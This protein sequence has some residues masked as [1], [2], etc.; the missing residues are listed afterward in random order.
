M[1]NSSEIRRLIKE[2]QL[3]TGYIDLEIQLQPTGFDLSLRAVQRYKGG[4]KV[5]FSNLE[6]EIAR[7]ELLEPDTD[8]WYN[9]EVGCYTIV[10]NEVVKIPLDVVAMARSR[11][12]LLRNG[13]TVQTAIWD[14]GYQGRS[15][16]LLVVSNPNGIRLKRDA[17]LTQLVFFG[18][19]KVQRG[20]DGIYQG[21]RM[22]R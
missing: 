16:S 10:Y 15:S 8:D 3:I 18:T 2:R 17:R 12:T 21:E 20:Y 14:P 1:F 4:G 13:A 7:K 5:D 9:L 6:R 19:D 22:T 11:S